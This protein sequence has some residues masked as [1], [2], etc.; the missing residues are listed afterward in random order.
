MVLVGP[1]QSGKTTLARALNGLYH[2]LEQAQERLRLD[3]V[4]EHQG[5]RWAIEIKLSTNPG[6][7]DLARLNQVA[8]LIDADRRFLISQSKLVVEGMKATACDLGW[9]LRR[10]A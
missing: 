7:E 3:L 9:F 5:E 8:E 6:P 10:I 4:L 2:D 1:R